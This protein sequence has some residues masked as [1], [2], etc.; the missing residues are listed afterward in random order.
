M[1]ANN[2][3][4]RGTRKMTIREI[5]TFGE[6]LTVWSPPIKRRTKEGKY[7]I[8]RQAERYI[9]QNNCAVKL[10]T[11]YIG[12]EEKIQMSEPKKVSDLYSKIKNVYDKNGVLIA[13]RSAPGQPLRLTGKGLAKLLIKQ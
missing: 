6:R 4:T 13:R 7:V 1:S 2:Q 10:I 8:T 11:Y 5:Q 9:M 12:K 3:R